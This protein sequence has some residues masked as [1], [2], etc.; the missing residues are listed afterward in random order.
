[1]LLVFLNQLDCSL[2]GLGDHDTN[3]LVDYL[4]GVLGVGFGHDWFTLLWQIKGEI[5]D[6]GGEAQLDDLLQG[7]KWEKHE[8]YLL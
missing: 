4:C 1:M 6:L 3:L 8:H 2:V 5:A 7:E